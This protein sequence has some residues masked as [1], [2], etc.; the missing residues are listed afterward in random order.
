MKA[1]EEVEIIQLHAFSASEQNGAEWPVLWTGHTTT[2]ER[3]PL[4]TGQ[5]AG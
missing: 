3:A 4:P 5:E 1:Y 2:M